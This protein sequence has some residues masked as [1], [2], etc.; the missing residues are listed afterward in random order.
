MSSLLSPGFPRMGASVKLGEDVP[1]HPI[2]TTVRR[3]RRYL[4]RSG[5]CSLACGQPRFRPPWLGSNHQ[6]NARFLV[7]RPVA[8]SERSDVRS[9]E[10]ANV[11]PAR[12]CGT[13]AD[14]AGTWTVS[15]PDG[16][17]SGSVMV[18]IAG[19]SALWDS[20]VVRQDRAGLMDLPAERLPSA[21]DSAVT[22][23]DREQTARLGLVDPSLR[24][25]TGWH[26]TGEFA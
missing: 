6:A 15:R 23:V 2:L 1:T 25:G 11:V 22:G 17:A 3:T 13:V 24:R 8:G 26:L 21:A 4:P 7:T 5:R 9:V 10:P 19:F 18:V 14:A 20:P 12:Q 16:K